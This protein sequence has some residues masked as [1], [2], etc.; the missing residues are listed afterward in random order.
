[1][2]STLKTALKIAAAVIIPGAA[3]FLLATLIMKE[4]ERREFKE[5]LRKT[6]GEASKYVDN[7]F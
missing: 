1:M 3:I 6:Y 7:Y 5:Y 4:S 2:N